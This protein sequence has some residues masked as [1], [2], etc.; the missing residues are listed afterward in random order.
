MQEYDEFFD[1]LKLLPQQCNV[2]KLND[3]IKRAKRLKIH[4]LLMEQ[5]VKKL[6]IEK[7]K[8]SYAKAWN[9]VNPEM[10]KLLDEF[11]VDDIPRMVSAVQSKN[12]KVDVPQALAETFK[13]LLDKV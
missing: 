9:K 2:R 10:M 11:I 6:F 4:A 3:V 7:A 1:E 13:K 12:K 5:L 8:L